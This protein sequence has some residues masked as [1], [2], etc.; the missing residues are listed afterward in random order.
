[1]RQDS[2]ARAPLCPQGRGAL[3]HQ[4]GLRAKVSPSAWL[5]ENGTLFVLFGQV[6]CRVR[7]HLSSTGGYLQRVEL[8]T[9]KGFYCRSTDYG[10]FHSCT[11]A[12]FQSD[13]FSCLHLETLVRLGIF[14]PPPVFSLSTE[15]EV[16]Q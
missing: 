1:M 16:S 13:G 14:P 12:E 11:C 7:L 9:P 10:D 6:F 15:T 8:R 5:R 3:T 4:R 2:S